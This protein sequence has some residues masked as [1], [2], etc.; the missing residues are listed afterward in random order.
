MSGVFEA[1]GVGPG[2]G[3]ALKKEFALPWGSCEAQDVP[4]GLIGGHA[5]PPAKALHELDGSQVAVDGEFA[6]YRDPS[7][8]RGNVV[9]VGPDG[10][11]IAKDGYDEFPLYRAKPAD[12]LIFSS[13]QRPLARVLGASPDLVGVRQFLNDGH[14]RGGRSFFM[15]IHRLRPG[16]VL[17]YDPQSGDLSIR[18]TSEAWVGIRE[19]PLPE[20]AEAAWAALNDAVRRSEALDVSNALMLSAGWDSRTLLA[21]MRPQIQDL[22][23][24]T[25]GDLQSRELQLLRRLVGPT[26]RHHEESL[27]DAYDLDAL[28]R[29]FGRIEN[30]LFPEWL[31]AGQVLSQH[32]VKCAS[33]GVYGEILGGHYGTT[34]VLSGHRKMVALLKELWGRGEDLDVDP[35]AFV[36]LSK[37]LPS[38]LNQ[39]AWPETI[40]D[41]VNHDIDSAFARLRDRGI[42]T[43][44]QLLEAF[45]SESRGTQYI[46]GQLL[47]CRAFTDVTLPFADRE[48]L[49][50][51]SQIPIKAKVHN[52]VNREILRRHDPGLLRT[53]TAAT[54]VPASYPIAVQEGTRAL[55]RGYGNLRWKLHFATGGRTEAPRFGWMILEFLRSGGFLDALVSDLRSDLWNKPALQQ[56]VADIKSCQPGTRTGV[57]T[58]VFL[59]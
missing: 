57:K 47:A 11:S 4:D 32:G 53:A 38:Y 13:R 12:G 59:R 21:A 52:I 27:A 45:I 30:V 41:E 26:A 56:Q 24:Y 29:G 28:Q 2:I 34:M 42:S 43:N 8:G 33:A 50:I 20:L 16:Q 31:R 51:A 36:K 1:A 5:L 49:L 23:Y 22:L 9:S 46:N 37:S 44:S 3:E 17:T 15:N 10:G 14:M 18:E 55:R 7:C 58:H 19:G 40:V 48:A 39:D 6:I 35:A 54:L 25:H